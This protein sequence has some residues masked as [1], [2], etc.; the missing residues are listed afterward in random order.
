[1]I[2]GLRPVLAALVTAP[3]AIVGGPA[4]AVTQ[5]ARVGGSATAGAAVI[6]DSPIGTVDDS[7]Q[8]GAHL[9]LSRVGG[10]DDAA[11]TRAGGE[12]TFQQGQRPI[13]F[14]M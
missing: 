2:S 13:S 14:T 10:R 3:I 11:G 5:I 9:C 8:V 6:G 12:Q 4:L 7:G 1:V